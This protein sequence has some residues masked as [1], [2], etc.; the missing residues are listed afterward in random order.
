[1][2]VPKLLLPFSVLPK[3]FL[4][5]V[6]GYGLRLNPNRQM[7]EDSNQADG[8]PLLAS[9]SKQRLSGWIWEAQG[10]G[11]GQTDEEWSTVDNCPY[12]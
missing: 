10:K 7:R 8:L 12:P 5:N 11:K 9:P 6:F 4:P 2:P 3:A 1:M